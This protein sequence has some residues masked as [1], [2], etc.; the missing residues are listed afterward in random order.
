MLSSCLYVELVAT[1]QDSPL[2]FYHSRIPKNKQKRTIVDE[3]LADADFRK[4][5]DYR[6]RLDGAYKR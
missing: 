2:D 5:T 3:L 4:Y 1:V 6:Y